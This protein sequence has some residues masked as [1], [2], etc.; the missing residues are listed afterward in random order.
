M[1]ETM[2][3]IRL[4]G[5]GGYDV[6]AVSDVPRPEAKSGWVRIQVK[7]FGVNESEVTSRQ[8]GSS[9]DFS[10]PRI[11]GIEAAGIVDQVAPGS[12][13]HVGDQVITMMGGMGRS[14]DGSYA[15]Y[16]V[17]PEEHVIGFTST[18]AWET[19]GALP[20]MFQTA[21]GSLTTGVGLQRGQS[22]LVHGGTSTVGLSAITLAH[23]LGARVLA[24][25]RNPARADLLRHHGADE[26]IVDDGEPI[27]SRIRVEHPDGIDAAIELVGLDTLPDTLA[28]LRRGG[29]CCFTGALNGAWTLPDFDPLQLIPTGV[30]LTSYAGQ[31]SELSADAFSDQLDAIAA[32]RI[33]PP[34]G[35]TYHG[36]EQVAHAHQALEEGH[37]LGKHVIVLD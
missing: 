37:A 4:T 34:I 18:L 27:A 6:L 12:R 25:T 2:R 13:F 23:D 30:R 8:G 21:H 32:G 11:L 19:I 35:A 3:A 33:I 17:V 9:A 5:P 1:S 16:T 36:L 22:L 15:E 31:A 10:Y 7:A 28:S 24:T 26:V 29:T 14:I 20:E